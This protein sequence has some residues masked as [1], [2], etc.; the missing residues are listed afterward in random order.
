[1]R[2]T[3]K[4]LYR[5]TAGRQFLDENSPPLDPDCTVAVTSAGKFFTNIAA[6]QLVERGILTLDEPINKFI[7]EIDKC[8]LVEKVQASDG[9]D[10]VAGSSEKVTLRKPVR[11]ITL[12]HCSTAQAAWALATHTNLY[13]AVM[14]LYRL[15]I[16]P[17]RLIFS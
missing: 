9:S 11:N 14:T 16:S 7:P 3:G 15:S 4:F 10:G 12:R 1:M 17:R 5:H 2:Y 13:L 6:L 8:L